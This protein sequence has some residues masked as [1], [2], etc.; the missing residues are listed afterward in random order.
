MAGAG[1]SEAGAPGAS[2]GAG[3]GGEGSVLSAPGDACD[4]DDACASGHCTDGVCCEST[5]DGVCSSCKGADTGG[6]DGQCLPVPLGEDPAEECAADVAA[7]NVGSC[8]G[9]GACQKAEDGT[10]CREQAGQCDVAEKC[11]AGKCGADEVAPAQTV[12]REKSGA[13]DIAEVCD[14]SSPTC[15]TDEFE[16]AETVCRP[17]AGPCD[18]ADECSG[19]SGSC[20]DLFATGT[21]AQCGDY[22]CSGA[23]AACSTACV[24]HAQCGTGAVCQQSK[25]VKGK[26][27]FVTST[28]YTAVVDGVSDADARCQARAVAAG[29]PGTF[30]AWFSKTTNTI[31]SRS[32][33]STQPYYRMDG[34]DPRVIANDWNDLVDGIFVAIATDEFGQI[35]GY[36]PAFTGTQYDG[37]ALANNCQN[38][39]SASAQDTFAAGNSS[40][41]GGTLPGENWSNYWSNPCNSLAHYY[42]IEQ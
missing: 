24:T 7:C 9:A 29:L 37:T 3:T 38:W 12:C 21:V 6:D 8:N 11:Q 39:N 19:S 30:K 40:A 23:A 26:R 2:A 35:Q 4:S 17:S 25:C 10:V 18:V 1:S 28:T 20:E 32:T 16:A 33:H 42:C 14:G 15:P 13:C 31:A 41:G 27:M 5:C 22:K 36:V 34:A